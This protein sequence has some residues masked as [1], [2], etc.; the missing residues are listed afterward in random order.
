[1][2]RDATRGGGASDDGG[3]RVAAGQRRPVSAGWSTRR[4][5]RERVSWSPLAVTKLRS[6][7]TWAPTTD[8]QA[9][10]ASADAR[11][12]QAAPAPGAHSADGHESIR[13][14]V[15]VGE[16]QL[17]PRCD[18][19]SAAGAL[20]CGASTEAPHPHQPYPPPHAGHTGGTGCRE[21]RPQRSQRAT[22]SGPPPAR[23]RA[24]TPRKVDGETGGLSAAADAKAGAALPGAAAM[25]VPTSRGRAPSGPVGVELT[26]PTRPL[27]ARAR[28]ARPA[29]PARR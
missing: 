17:S 15:D 18:W 11:G 26:W 19:M 21:T 24:S 5:T 2:P 25:S 6:I 7:V 28:H 10:K 4:G 23:G 9:S 1:M 12:G 20:A 22:S 8:A 27:R 29:R 14:H 13:A 3:A 16:P